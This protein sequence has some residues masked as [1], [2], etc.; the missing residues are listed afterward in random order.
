MDD[1]WDKRTAVNLV[2]QKVE[3]MD[4]T[5]VSLLVDGSV[6]DEVAYLVLR[7]VAK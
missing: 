4:D 3:K 6:H 1:E 7:M 2:V 5:K